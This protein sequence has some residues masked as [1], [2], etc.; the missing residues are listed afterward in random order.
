MA[1]ILAAPAHSGGA[2]NRGRLPPSCSRQHH[3]G[4]KVC[5]LPGIVKRPP[6]EVPRRMAGAEN[7]ACLHIWAAPLSI[8]RHAC[9]SPAANKGQQANGRAAQALAVS[10]APAAPQEYSSLAQAAA[11]LAHA[12]RS[13]AQSPLLQETP[14]GGIRDS[15]QVRSSGLAAWG[16]L[17]SGSADCTGLDA[18]TGYA[19]KRSLCC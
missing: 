5:T 13:L 9:F 16:W 19:A 10:G 8:A 12:A 4:F 2:A 3:P 18:W 17:C 7:T 1:P 6:L 14:P 11:T 15:Y